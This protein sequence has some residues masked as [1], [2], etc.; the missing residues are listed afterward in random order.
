MKSSSQKHVRLA[1]R[2]DERHSFND[3]SY[4]VDGKET[5]GSDTASRGTSATH[6]QTHRQTI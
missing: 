6:R 5:K 3:A 4:R 2:V 1:H